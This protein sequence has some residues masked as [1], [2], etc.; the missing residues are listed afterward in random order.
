[1]SRYPKGHVLFGTNIIES[2]VPRNNF[3]VFFILYQI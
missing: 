1:M 2:N 3:I